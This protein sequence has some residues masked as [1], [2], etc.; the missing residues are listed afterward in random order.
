MRDVDIYKVLMEHGV[1]LAT[2]AET[3]KII[4]AV[5]AILNANDK[6]S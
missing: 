3:E 1:S 4:A 5:R 2:T 6:K